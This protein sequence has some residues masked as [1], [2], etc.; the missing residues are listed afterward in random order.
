MRI[1]WNNRAKILSHVREVVMAV[2]TTLSVEAAIEELMMDEDSERELVSSDEATVDEEES[3]FPDK[4]PVPT[5]V[6]DMPASSSKSTTVPSAYSM[7]RPPTS[8][9]LSRKRAIDRNP[10]P[11]GKKRAKGPNRQSDPKSIT[12]EQRVKDARYA[13]ECLTVSNKN[14]FCRACREE[15]SVKTSVINNH[16][17][18]NKHKS[19]KLR[20]DKKRISD[21]EIVEALKSYDKA[22]NPKGETLPE[23]Q[24]LYRIRVVRTFLLA[25]VPLTYSIEF[26]SVQFN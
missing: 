13:N 18:S 4:T 9:Q 1:F 17:K 11:K 15:V 25:G 5:N 3:V 8:S 10:P 7:L 24:R 14:L 2:K 16:I 19:S 6:C 22:E 23:E 20:L 12:P 21:V 26:S